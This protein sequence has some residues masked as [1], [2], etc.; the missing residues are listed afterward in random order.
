MRNARKRAC[1]IGATSP[2][3]FV[4]AMLESIAAVIAIFFLSKLIVP[5]M[6]SWVAHIGN[7]EHLTLFVIFIILI[8]GW[9]SQKMGLTLAMGALIAGMII[10]DSEYNHQIILDILPLRDYFSSIFFISIGMLLQIQIFFDC[11]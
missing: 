8:T 4:I 6:L 11:C 3:D 5:R 10:S 9:I 2:I 1:K 7:K